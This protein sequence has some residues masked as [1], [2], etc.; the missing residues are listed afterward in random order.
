MKRSYELQ[1]L[2]SI[3]TLLIS[4]YL[5]MKYVIDILNQYPNQTSFIKH[6][7]FPTQPCI[8]GC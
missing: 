7:D 2:N 1:I 4:S 3:L 6:T 8:Y 5:D